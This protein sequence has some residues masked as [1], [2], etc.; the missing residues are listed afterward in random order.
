MVHTVHFGRPSQCCISGSSNNSCALADLDCKLKLPNVR[1]SKHALKRIIERGYLISEINKMLGHIDRHI[2]LQIVTV[3]PKQK[4]CK[5]LLK[6]ES[7]EEEHEF[8]S[9]ESTNNTNSI[10]IDSTAIDYV[11]QLREA[12]ATLKQCKKKKSQKKWTAK[13]AQLEQL[14]SINPLPELSNTQ[15]RLCRRIAKA[16][17]KLKET[18]SEKEQQ[19]IVNRIRI[20]KSRLFE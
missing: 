11:K 2:I 3:L 17:S 6:E 8:D 15:M 16:E 14:V 18:L 7:D 4:P 9:T 12:K 10:D 1:C 5:T 19:K 13:V 20:L